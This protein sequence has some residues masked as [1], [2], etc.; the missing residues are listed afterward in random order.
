MHCLAG[1]DTLT[2]GSVFIGTVAPG[3]L[4]ER[5]LTRLRRD[6][7]GFVFQPSTWSRPDCGREQHPPGPRR[8]PPRA[9][10]SR[11]DTVLADEPA[12]NLGSRAGAELL[13]FL[14]QAVDA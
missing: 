6:R 7:I 8:P 10:L 1:L 4:G 13:G 12:V 2:A 11:P 14:R 5:E 3:S 9:L